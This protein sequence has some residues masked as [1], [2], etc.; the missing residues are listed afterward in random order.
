MKVFQITHKYHPYIKYFEQKYGLENKPITFQEHIKLI[1]KDGYITCH[2]LEP[3]FKDSYSSFYTIYDYEVL[4]IK[5]AKES[6]YESTDLREI[7]KLQIEKEKPDVIY[8]LSTHFIGKDFFESLSFR[9]KLICWNADAGSIDKLNFKFYDVL[10]SSSVRAIEKYD[11]ARLFHPSYEP[12]MD[13]FKNKTKQ[14]DLV[15]YGQYDNGLFKERKEYLDHLVNFCL[16]KKLSFKFCLMFKETKTPLI[17]RRFLWKLPFLQKFDPP[18]R[19]SKH[20]SP[21]VFG[22]DIYEL[23]SSS[24]IVFNISGG[25]NEFGN[26]K[27]NN[28]IFETLGVGTFMLSDEGT[29]PEHMESGVHFE[30][31]KDLNDLTDKI[32]YFL[33]HDEEREAIA[34]EGNKMIKDFYSKENQWRK[35]Q[36]LINEIDE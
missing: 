28:R 20:F 3:F 12:F 21:P 34:E 5:W 8:N 2:L 26:Y 7:L 23:I 24:K 11:N 30:T 29:Y 13:S 36:E 1:I 33:S 9:P 16:K 22:K 4:Q 19:I 14:Y 27:F 32:E 31:Y 35:F 10:L 6:G 17:N 25:I 15:F 18:K